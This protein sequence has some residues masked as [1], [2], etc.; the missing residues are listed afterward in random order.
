MTLDKTGILPFAMLL[1]IANAHNVLGGQSSANDEDANKAAVGSLQTFEQ[2]VTP[3]NVKAYGFDSPGSVVKSKV[4]QP[5]RD[6]VIALDS[7]QKW[8]G[9][10]ASSIIKQTGRMIYPIYSN[11]TTN[12]FVTIAFKEGRWVP[13]AFGDTREA[14]MISRIRDKINADAPGGGNIGT[15][16]QVRV[17][18]LNLKFLANTVNSE[19]ILTPMQ[20]V[21][22]LDIT[23]GKGELATAVLRRVQKSAVTINPD[24]PN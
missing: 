13:I 8:D 16:T 18:A 17:P 5:V 7:L 9:K 23:S 3:E 15:V 11:G 4:G 10:D 14:Q 22:A 6:Y 1:I 2:L 20:S 19:L 12:S 24:A 21:S